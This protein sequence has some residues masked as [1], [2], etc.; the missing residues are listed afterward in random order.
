LVHIAAGF[1]EGTWEDK[2]ASDSTVGVP[3]AAPDSNGGAMRSPHHEHTKDGLGAEDFRR[4]RGL[5][6]C[7]GGIRKH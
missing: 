1:A 5:E 3:P 4:N 2:A 7:L 6:S